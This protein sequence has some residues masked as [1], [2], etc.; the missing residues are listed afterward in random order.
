MN[1]RKKAAVIGA[2]LGG[3]AAAV[4]L[5][6]LGFEVKV[7]EKQL[8]P[9][10]KAGELTINGFRF[11]LGP[12]LLTMPDI[13]EDLFSFAGESVSDYLQI[14][15]AKISCK[16]FY[17]DGKK[18]NAY[19]DTN[20][21]INEVAEVTGIAKEILENYLDYTKR[22]YDISGELF[23]KKSFY[24]P[25]ILL[26]GKA[27][28][29]LLNL[30]QLDL[31]RSMHKANEVK[32]ANDYAVKLFDRYAT[33]NG[34]NPYEAPATLNIIPHVEHNLGTFYCKGGIYA[35][36][37]A[38]YKLAEK[39]GTKFFFN[40]EIEKIKLENKT[41]KGIEY[42]QNGE[43][44]T[45]EFDFVISNA[46]VNFTY[47]HLLN[48]NKT[49][50]AKRYKKLEPSSSAVVF[51]WGIQGIHKELN[52]HNIIFSEDYRKEFHQ[53]F[54]DRKVPDDPTIYI[55]I[56]SKFNEEDSPQN[57][58]NWFVMINSP[59]NKGQ[60]W[61]EQIKNTRKQIFEKINKVLNID[62]KSKILF[63]QILDPLS[64]EKN[65]NSSFGSLYGISSNSRFAAFLRQQNKSSTYKHLYFTGGS[66][67][68]GGGIPLVLL[69]A[70]ITVDLIENY[71]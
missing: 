29:A 28:K 56:S 52:A 14:K 68:P 12:S 57:S 32:L 5:S 2:G 70:K 67:H 3:L 53:I 13:I 38:I 45:E 33:Y 59:Y 10:G 4:R 46:D 17:N 69:S 41:V 43:I 61:Q 7:F 19:S 42:K 25:S 71:E 35:I 34:S 24:N 22:I 49:R 60:N 18:I 9:G 16:Y 30:K 66:A 47:S 55:Y 63:E 8:N 37:K 36:T 51:Y 50:I 21:F 1:K 48:D 62:I 20:K 23:L 65:M 58:E 15:K 40:T 11:D 64:I 26:S 44:K 31:F 39:I 27:L 6:K 54:K